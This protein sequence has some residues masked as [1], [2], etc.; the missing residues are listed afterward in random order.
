MPLSVASVRAHEDVVRVLL[1]AGATPDSPGIAN[2]RTAFSYAAE[3]GMEG[4]VR[5]FL[6]YGV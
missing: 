4:I 2:G 3:D 5:L 6:K 1:E